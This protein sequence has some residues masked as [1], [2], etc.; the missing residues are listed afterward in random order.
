MRILKFF[1][2]LFFISPSV[3]LAN[4]QYNLPEGVTQ[5][6]HAVYG[7]H[8]TVFWV[9]VA[10][11][12]VVFGAM[13][14][15]ILFHRKSRGHK[16]AQFHEHLWLE[17]SWSIVPFLILVVLAI[18]ATRVLAHMNDYD[19]SDIT[20][21]VTGYQWKWR[22]EYLDQDIHF[23]S[24][25]STPMDERI[26][27]KAKNPAY[28]REVD[29]PLVVPVH[30]KIRFL[31]T[32]NDV[33]HSWSVPYLAIKREAV[34]GFINEA[35]ARISRPG[36][37]YGQCSELCGLNHAY[38]PIVVIA[39]S[40]KEFADWI[41]K[42]KGIVATPSTTTPIQPPTPALPATQ[43]KALPITPKPLPTTPSPAPSTVTQPPITPP[44]PGVTAKPL[45]EVLKEGEQI[46]LTTCA[47]CHQP[48][49]EGLPPTY[50]SLKG[51]A[52]PKGPLSAHIDRVLNGKPGTAMQAFKEQFND[53]ELAAVITYERNAWGNNSGEVVKPEEIKAARK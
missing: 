53:D 25:I 21:K 14:Y 45:P 43:S 29:H 30:K 40:E 31:I 42:Q 22:Y 49:G 6:S 44:H 36:I 46:Y 12:F 28:L 23:F 47:A 18:P 52:I 13:I 15:S 24:N 34:P 51:G 1:V 38:M 26:G 19:L 17:I 8:M 39:L 7:L 37:Y 41:N 20:V 11:G 2:L 16:A 27:K 33:L 32:S 3:A 50:P 9:C 4:W 35:W 48:T 10:I 5:V